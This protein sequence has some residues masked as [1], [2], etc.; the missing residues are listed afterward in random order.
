MDN[1]LADGSSYNAAIGAHVLCLYEK[2]REA[3]ALSMATGT[4]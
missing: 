4:S 2:V 3:A 1:R